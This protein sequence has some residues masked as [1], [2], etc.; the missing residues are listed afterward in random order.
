MTRHLREMRRRRIGTPSLTDCLPCVIVSGGVRYPYPDL[1]DA[2]DHAH[3][4]PPPMTIVDARDPL[5]VYA[6]DG[7]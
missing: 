1:Y 4:Y 3:L 5:V 7:R 2:L 6:T